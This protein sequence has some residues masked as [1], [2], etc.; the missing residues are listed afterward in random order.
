M[1]LAQLLAPYGIDE[2]DLVDA[3]S[4][5]LSPT[6]SAGLPASVQE[7]L[8]QGGLDFAD[9]DAVAHTVAAQA[10]AQE[11]EL[12]AGAVT[13]QEAAVR[14]EVSASRVRHLVADKQLVAIRTSRRLLLPAWQFDD[15]GKP[16]RGLRDVLKHARSPE[17]PLAMQAFMTTP[18]NELQVDG[19]VMTPREWLISGG[20]PDDLAELLAGD[21]W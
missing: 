21:V 4:A 1:S 14:M 3:I 7:L 20:K 2:Q 5:R 10:V 11:T 12:L 17:H 8:E 9:S 16:L 15:D 6:A 13:V 18:Q 19:R